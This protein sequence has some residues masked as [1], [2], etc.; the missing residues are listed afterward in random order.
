MEKLRLFLCCSS[1]CRPF[2]ALKKEANNGFQFSEEEVTKSP[3]EEESEGSLHPPFRGRAEAVSSAGLK[4][5]RPALPFPCEQPES[6]QAPLVAA[7]H[8]AVQQTVTA[9]GRQAQLDLFRDLHKEQ[10]VSCFV[11]P[12]NYSKPQR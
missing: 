3:A 6:P 9:D 5:S 10:H 11:F 1:P 4:P 2:H 7:S 12:F 8:K